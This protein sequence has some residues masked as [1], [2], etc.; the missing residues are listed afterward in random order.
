MTRARKTGMCPVAAL[1]LLLCAALAQADDL[2]RDAALRVQDRLDV[3]ELSSRYAWGID[4]LDRALLA[5]TFT[6]DAVAEFVGVGENPFAV[7]VRL[8]GFEKIFNWLDRSGGAR[9]T[10]ETLPWHFVTNHLVDVQGNAATMKFFLHGR[11]MA[12]GGIVTVT[13]ARDAEGWRIRYLKVEAQ[14]W[15]PAKAS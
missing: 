15:T 6:P 14:R 12:S 1:G 4:T 11:D 7:N 5:R 9:K 10:W 3:I 13:A 8:D 2:E